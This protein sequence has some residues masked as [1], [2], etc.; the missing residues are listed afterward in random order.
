MRERA[1]DL[2]RPLGARG[3]GAR[4]RVAGLC[5]V[6]AIAASIALCAGRAA[7][8]TASDDAPAG[9][10]AGRVVDS[11]GS[12][13]PGVRIYIV[14]AEI[15][16]RRPGSV[17]S[18]QDGRFAWS[19][20]SGFPYRLSAERG[21]LGSRRAV[22]VNSPDEDV[23]IVLERLGRIIARVAKPSG[24][25]HSELVRVLVEDLESP[26]SP[27]WG[28]RR[29]LNEFGE[30]VAHHL[31]DG[32]HMLQLMPT[33]YGWS[34]HPVTIADG[35]TVDLGVIELRPG[36]NISGQVLSDGQPVADATVLVLENHSIVAWSDT[37]GRF[38]IADAPSRDVELLVGKSGY[39]NVEIIVS[40]ARPVA[41]VSLPRLATL[42]VLVLSDFAGWTLELRE[43][44][45]GQPR[46]QRLP[47]GEDSRR[48]LETV[49][50][51][52]W[53]LVWRS[54]LDPGLVRVVQELTVSAGENRFI[55]VKAPA[56]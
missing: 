56:E 48:G 5:S 15:P 20:L 9:R 51:G 14:Q 43:L 34:L 29:K 45:S 25:P 33:G 3:P 6:Y 13:V 24:E 41:T 38:T 23:E 35:A 44:T 18:D 2:R 52:R 42:E 36:F 10:V 12:S 39:G 26:G 16:H 28:G 7:K 49:P 55:S 19:D 50:P 40:P 54:T 53:S 1:N 11:R 27:A 32:R 8:L 47:L 21:P 30:L 46:V 37:L 31:P 17:V 4:R 22:L